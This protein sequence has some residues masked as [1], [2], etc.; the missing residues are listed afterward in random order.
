MKTTIYRQNK[1]IYDDV[2][3]LYLSK[4]IFEDIDE[5]DA[6]R[7]GVIDS[8]GNVVNK[9]Y[10]GESFSNLD[11]FVLAIKQRIGE[12]NLRDLLS[13][14]SKVKDVSA[15]RI[16]NSA[17]RPVNFSELDYLKKIVAKI[18]SLSF[19]PDSDPNYSHI[20]SDDNDIE[21]GTMEYRISRSL[22]IATMLLYS[23]KSAKKINKVDFTENVIPS[24]EVTFHIKACDEYDELLEFVTKHQLMTENTISNKAVK[25][26]VAIGRDM[27]DGNLLTHDSSRIENQSNNWELLGKRYVG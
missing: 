7:D 3:M 17:N 26:L 12:D 10:K 24:V 11:K 6:Y 1:K 21:H 14:F 5:T 16:M 8:V 2:A 4:R 15:L 18:E 22:T 9:N 20:E 13:S 23:L 19:L 25:T 27:M